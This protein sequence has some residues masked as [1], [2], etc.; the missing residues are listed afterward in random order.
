MNGTLLYVAERFKFFLRKRKQIGKCSHS[1]DIKS[2]KATF[3]R[4]GY[5]P[6][7]KWVVRGIKVKIY[8]ILYTLAVEKILRLVYFGVLSKCFLCIQMLT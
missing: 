8:D 3:Q 2:L 6:K 1:F 5:I 7:L 4:A